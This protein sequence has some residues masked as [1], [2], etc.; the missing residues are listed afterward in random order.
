MLCCNATV[1]RNPSTLIIYLPFFPFFLLLLLFY[2]FLSHFCSC[3]YRLKERLHQKNQLHFQK[4]HQQASHSFFSFSSLPSSSTQSLCTLNLQSH[5]PLHHQPFSPSSKL[6]FFFFLLILLP[7]LT[8]MLITGE[9]NVVSPKNVLFTANVHRCVLR[10]C[11]CVCL[12]QLWTWRGQ[13]A[14]HS[15]DVME[16][17]LRGGWQTGF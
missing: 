16:N 7:H 5:P 11:A 3:I 8:A 10:L 17:D 4:H 6:L 2:L 15:P 9:I 14:P 13:S 12:G 1:I